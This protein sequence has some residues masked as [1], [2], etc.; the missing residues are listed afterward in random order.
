MASLPVV[1]VVGLGAVALLR[2]LAEQE[3]KA[4]MERVRVRAQQH[5][6]SA[7]QDVAVLLDMT[8]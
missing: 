4:N 5:V 8:R 6:L 7:M 3:K 2:H 1:T